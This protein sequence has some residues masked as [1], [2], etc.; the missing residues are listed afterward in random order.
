[1]YSLRNKV[2]GLLLFTTLT[3]TSAPASAGFVDWLRWLFKIPAPVEETVTPEPT[4][5]GNPDLYPD[6]L[7]PAIFVG[8]NWDGTIDVIDGDN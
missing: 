6:G 4:E 1:M 3:F 2:S 5:P 8:N 7:R